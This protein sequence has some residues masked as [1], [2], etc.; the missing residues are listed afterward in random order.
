MQYNVYNNYKYYKIEFDALSKK[1]IEGELDTFHADLNNRLT[2]LKKL[3]YIDDNGVLSAKGTCATS[4]ETIDELLL[5][6]LIFDGFFN[7]LDEMESIVSLTPFA[8]EMCNIRQDKTYSMKDKTPNISDKIKKKYDIFREKL[9]KII[10]IKLECNIKGIET[11]KDVIMDKYNT[12]LMPIM[13]AWVNG[14]PFKKITEM[15]TIME[16]SIVR[17]FKNVDEICRQIID[18]FHSIGDETLINKFK[19][20]RE[21]LRR[22]VIFV[23]SLYVDGIDD[24]SDDEDMNDSD[25]G[26]DSDNGDDDD[27]MNMNNDNNHDSNNSNNSSSN[28]NKN[29]NEANDD[30][31]MN[32]NNNDTNNDINDG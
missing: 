26:N 21:K 19:N 30:E 17:A 22:G 28:I 27:D 4:F 12:E 8:T 9:L 16:G 14:E 3:K 5:T 11:D 18:A 32:D 13:I 20:A 6:E 25:T 15:S 10:D 1:D 23:S 24:N 31:D 2:V 29:S 7:D